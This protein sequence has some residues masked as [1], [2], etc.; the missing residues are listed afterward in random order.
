MSQQIN[1]FEGGLVK[2]K[3]WFTLPVV[4]LV[5]ALA[6]GVMFYLFTGLEA[7][8]AALQTQRNQAVAQYETMQKKVD[9][10]AQQVTPVDNSKLEA[11]LKSLNGRF[12][13]QSQ[14]LVIFQQ[15]ISDKASH[16]VDYMRALTAQQQPGLWLTGFRIEPAAQHVTL[17]GQALHSEDIPLYL[18][19]LSAQR[20]FEGTQFAGIQFKQTDLHRTQVAATPA[21]AP[22]AATPRPGG[23]TETPAIAGK[24]AAQAAANTNAAPVTT[25]APVA[26]ADVTLQVYAFEVKGQDLQNKARRETTVSWDEFVRQTTQSPAKQP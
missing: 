2:S 7:E 15:S 16:L 25:T 22:Q 13:M 10:F 11:E 26:A 24:E 19:L 8:S 18:D 5:Y 3:D 21:T 12:D 1:L 9:A 23:A 17:N 4:A 14:I 20:V 6:A